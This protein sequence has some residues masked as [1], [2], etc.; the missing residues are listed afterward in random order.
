MKIVHPQS[1]LRIWWRCLCQCFFFFFHTVAS[2]SRRELREAGSVT[3]KVAGES[4]QEH[5]SLSGSIQGKFQRTKL[6]QSFSEKHNWTEGEGQFSGLWELQNGDVDWKKKKR[7]KRKRKPTCTSI[8][9][10]VN[11]V[12]F[13]WWLNYPFEIV[14]LIRDMQMVSKISTGSKFVFT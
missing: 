5:G 12:Q 3:C 6:S 2:Q 11:R 14:N 7:K 13:Q 1:C 4:W 10:V 8:N 9:I